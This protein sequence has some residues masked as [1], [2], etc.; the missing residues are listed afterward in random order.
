VS[1]AAVERA[2][3]AWFDRVQS[4]RMDEGRK[5]PG[6]GLWTWDD[7]TADDQRAYRALVAPIVAAALAADPSP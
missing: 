3:V 1:E 5:R 2:A 6:G 4:Q 7:L